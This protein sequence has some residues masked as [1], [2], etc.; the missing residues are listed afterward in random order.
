MLRCRAWFGSH[1]A[2]RTT[3]LS[4]SSQEGFSEARIRVTADVSIDGLDC[5]ESQD[6]T[7]G[8]G[9]QQKACRRLT[10]WGITTT[11]SM[12]NEGGARLCMN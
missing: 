1:V 5:I 7:P 6:L 4:A 12:T 9:L 3:S 11:S 2:A 8:L 10:E